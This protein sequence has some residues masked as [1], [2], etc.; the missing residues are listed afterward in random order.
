MV[1]GV[2]L[3]CKIHRLFEKTKYSEKEAGNGFLEKSIVLHFIGLI[4]GLPPPI[5]PALTRSSAANFFGEAINLRFR[6]F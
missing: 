5:D 4:S 3:C 6:N 1:L 2:L